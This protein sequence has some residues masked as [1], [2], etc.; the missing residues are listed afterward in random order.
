MNPR[1]VGLPVAFLLVLVSATATQAQTIRVTGFRDTPT[2]TVLTLEAHDFDLTKVTV[3]GLYHV[4]PA[5]PFPVNSL[6]TTGAVQQTGG[7]SVFTLDIH[8]H[9]N[10]G[11]SYVLALLPV[12]KQCSEDCIKLQIDRSNP[13]TTFSNLPAPEPESLPVGPSF[14]CFSHYWQQAPCLES[15]EVEVAST[16][17]KREFLREKVQESEV[18]EGFDTFNIAFATEWQIR[19]RSAPLLEESLMLGLTRVR[20]ELDRT[21]IRKVAFTQFQD[22]EVSVENDR[23]RVDSDWMF[24][25]GLGNRW[26]DEEG[27]AGEKRL[28]RAMGLYLGLGVETQ[29]FSAKR[30]I[31]PADDPALMLTA[32]IDLKLPRPVLLDPQIGIKFQAANPTK[33]AKLAFTPS[34]NLRSPDRAPGTLQFNSR[35]RRQ[36]GLLW[37]GQY[38]SRFGSTGPEYE[39]TMEGRLTF[40]TGEDTLGDTRFRLR[41]SFE[42]DLPIAGR[43]KFKPYVEIFLFTS[44][45]PD[46]SSLPVGQVPRG[47]FW[48]IRQGVKFALQE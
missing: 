37:E 7:R 6:L 18:K 44:Q 31:D 13:R 1:P 45:K 11:E 29:F 3:V 36:F 24:T 10:T 4:D 21:R 27:S 20:A 9:L 39:T 30:T 40:P 33:F 23:F 5:H 47:L 35:V 26:T 19:T 38:N 41:S 48:S 43:F 17:T 16:L 28:W 32:P 34:V 2:L 22:P 14:F 25:R 15:V 42:L 8:G 46:S 12:G